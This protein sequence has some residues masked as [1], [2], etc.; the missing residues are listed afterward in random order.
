MFVLGIFLFFC[1]DFSVATFTVLERLTIVSVKHQFFIVLNSSVPFFSENIV[2]SSFSR[3]KVFLWSF[4]LG[5]GFIVFSSVFCFSCKKHRPFKLVP[6]RICGNVA[7][8]RT[9]SQVIRGVCALSSLQ[10]RLEGWESRHLYLLRALSWSHKLDCL[11]CSRRGLVLRRRTGALM[12]ASE[13]AV[14]EEELR[15]LSL[16]EVELCPSFSVREVFAVEASGESIWDSGVPEVPDNERSLN[17]FYV[18]FW[19][20]CTE[21][22]TSR[23]SPN[24]GIR[25]RLLMCR[26]RAC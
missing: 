10:V 7:G 6:A 16:P 22:E 5:R 24:C 8:L 17:F 26:I 2:F 4:L 1:F 3:R 9:R 13:A 15:G 20:R 12:S 11:V 18:S 19:M 21:V 23:V 14:M 25:L